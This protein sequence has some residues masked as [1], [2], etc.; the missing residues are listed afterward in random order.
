MWLLF[1]INVVLVLLE[2]LVKLSC[3]KY[4][5]NPQ[6]IVP[7]H[8]FQ[9]QPPEM[10]CKKRG[11]LKKFANFMGKHL[12]WSL[13]LIKLQ[14]IR[15]ATLLK[16]NSST[17]VFLWNL[18]NFKEPL[19]WRNALLSSKNAS[20]HSSCFV[21]WSPVFQLNYVFFWHIFFSSL[22]PGFSFFTPSKMTQN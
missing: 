8:Y 9:K 12:Y 22:I 20:N 13:F 10:F 11:V 16:R 14:A 18:R 3:S 21:I 4:W 2:E 7:V 15:P 1:E 19:F 17:G 5:R 6:I